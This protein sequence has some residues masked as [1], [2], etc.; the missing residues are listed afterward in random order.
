MFLFWVGGGLGG[1]SNGLEPSD[2]NQAGS[3][4]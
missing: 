1:G 4:M 3:Y 2:H